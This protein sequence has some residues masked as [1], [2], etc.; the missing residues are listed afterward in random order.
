MEEKGK[1]KSPKKKCS[2]YHFRDRGIVNKSIKVLVK[3]WC[4]HVIY[5]TTISHVK[6]NQLS[7]INEK[8]ERRIT[9]SFPHLAKVSAPFYFVPHEP[10]RQ[11][12]FLTGGPKWGRV[13]DHYISVPLWQESF[14]INMAE[15]LVEREVSD[16]EQSPTGRALAQD[17]VTGRSA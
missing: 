13:F 15:A 9:R 3:R 17:G 10:H 16:P 14:L 8:S 2:I 4:S 5:G 7:L 11:S 12:V 6:H 1:R